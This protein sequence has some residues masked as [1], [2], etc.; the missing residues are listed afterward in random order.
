MINAAIRSRKQ[1]LGGLPRMLT[2]VAHFLAAE[3]DR[4]ADDVGME[5]L[6]LGD[7]AGEH[8]GGC[9]LDQPTKE[10]EIPSVQRLVS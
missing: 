7:D 5:L 2:P 8:R 4:L 9:R 6:A 1:S 3:H 10:R